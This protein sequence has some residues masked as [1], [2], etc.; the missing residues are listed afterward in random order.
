MSVIGSSLTL[1]AT[2]PAA[3]ANIE[4]RAPQRHLE[5]HHLH[6]GEKLAAT[7]WRDG[8]FDP[9]ALDSINRVLRDFR[10]G[11]VYPI[12]QILLDLL[13]QVK[14]ELGT[15]GH[16]EVIGG[17]RSPKTNNMLR[18]RT[19]GVAK[20]SLHM[21]GRAIDVRI[22]GVSTQRLREAAADLRRGG[23]GYYAKSNF[24]HIDTGR[25]RTW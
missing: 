6:T 10:T 25:P 17:Y 24:V 7:Y 1:A 16:Y 14:S 20:K 21:Q 2:A 4:S 19:T 18:Q 22:P 11:D 8:G 5:F 9:G 15:D 23:V 3:L 13:H 12:E